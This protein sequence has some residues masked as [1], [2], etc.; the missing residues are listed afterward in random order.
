MNITMY[1]IFLW[2]IIYFFIIHKEQPK[3]RKQTIIHHINNK[4]TKE[5]NKMIEFIKEFLNKECIIYTLDEK[6]IEATI[7]SVSESGN[8][9]LVTTT[10]DN[11]KQV[12]NLEYVSRIRE[13]PIDPKTGKRA[14]YVLD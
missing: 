2:L 6:A 13:Y 10:K 7:N 12:I 9:I 3:H 5:N 4:K 8:A 1:F 14:K 11:N